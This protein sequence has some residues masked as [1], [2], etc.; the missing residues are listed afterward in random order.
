MISEGFVEIIIS[1]EKP[2]YGAKLSFSTDGGTT[3]NPC[4]AYRGLD[5]D[6]LLDCSFWEWNQ[7][8]QFGNL[9]F[10]GESR[11]VYWNLHLNSLHQHQGPVTLRVEAIRADGVETNETVL[12]LEPSRA[13]YLSDW[14]RWL[15]PDS[16]W[17][18]EN[19]NLAVEEGKGRQPF[20]IT[21]GLTGRFKVVL[22]VPGGAFIARLKMSDEP[23]HYPFFAL[24]NHPEFQHK[25]NKELCWKT[26]TLAPDSVLEID[27]PE[28]AI[29]EPKHY[30][31]GLLKYIKF[32]PVAA[33]AAPR[34]TTWADKKL[35][36]YFE[37]YSW[38][39]MYNLI[40]RDQVREALAVFR[41]MGADE[42]HTQVLRFGTRS[43]YH[44]R[45]IE[46]YD[47]GQI[48]GDDG[49]FST[50]P[51]DMVR[52]L[53]ALREDIDIC[54]EL[55]MTHFANAGITCCYTGSALEDRFS[56]E[57]PEYRQDHTLRY[58]RP[59][60]VAYVQSII[61]EFVEWKTDAVS[62]DGMRYPYFHTEEDLLALFR[63]IR[64]TLDETSPDRKIPLAVRIPAGDVAW[65]R[66]FDQLAREGAVQRVI[67]A[68]LL[69]VQSG[70]TLKPYLK[71]KDFG[72][73]IFGLVD[74][75]KTC[76]WDN[77]DIHLTPA[78]I[79][80]IV[81]RHFNEGADGI[82][83]YQADLHLADAFARTALDWRKW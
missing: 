62:I 9:K 51:L 55:G 77:N 27:L 42:I 23:N 82:F 59:E 68:N 20:C 50:G 17:K 25:I 80:E 78:D 52:S 76:L 54:H 18:I 37:P 46:R 36:M 1:G 53:D 19:G 15:V 12:D 45:V 29:R 5:A 70:F 16:G 41:E 67:P 32:V 75:W 3:F 28:I 49:T 22:C 31:F 83:V 24:K 30:P 11:P 21:P 34:K 10:D 64:E 58:N 60:T 38:A 35:A 7:A 57:H 40:T 8:A 48:A 56:R 63:G 79:R 39:F 66:A 44:S 72:C 61:R 43:M 2:L 74:G 69:N 26:V 14:Q 81:T 33:S 4:A 47:S 71:W 73:E 13:V 6:S 65:F